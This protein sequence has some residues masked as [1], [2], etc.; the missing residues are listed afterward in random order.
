MA[1]SDDNVLKVGGSSDPKAVASV[2]AHAIYQGKQPV[3]RAIGAS[4]VNQALKACI[5]ARGFCAPRGIDLVFKPGFED[6]TGE[7]GNE[8]SCITI[9]AIPM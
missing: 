6:V 4:A 8:I 1:L 9:R 7:S 3:M 2:I 5:V